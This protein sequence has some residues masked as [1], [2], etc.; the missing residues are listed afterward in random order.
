MS[1]TIVSTLPWELVEDK[2]TL[3]PHKYVIPAAKTNDVSVLA[4]D[5]AAYF[6]FIPLSNEK[7][8]PLRV[9]VPSR[10]VARSIVDDFIGSMSGVDFA[11]NDDGIVAMPGLFYLPDV[12]LT[13]EVVKMKHK[14]QVEQALKNTKLW[15][16]NLVRVADDE[17]FRTH[18]Y[19]AISDIQRRA[20][21]FLGLDR[22]W[23]KDVVFLQQT[24]CWA[25]KTKIHGE[26]MI[27]HNCKAIVNA[28]E[29]EKNKARFAS[30]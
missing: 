1:S 17:W 9:P 20:V 21:K 14:T 30:V 15:F 16:T 3:I 12:S 11:P 22:E 29:Y 18:Q 13:A 2:V 28:V 19:Q 8:P 26:A 24:D 27:C 23:I 5:D 6:R 4:V 10:D 25:C 7:T